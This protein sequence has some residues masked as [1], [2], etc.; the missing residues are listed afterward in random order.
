VSS[1]KELL[2]QQVQISNQIRAVR[3][4]LSE[5][6]NIQDYR[7]LEHE[8]KI[9]GAEKESL[10]AEL[11]LLKTNKREDNRYETVFIMMCKNMLDADTYASIVDATTKRIEGNSK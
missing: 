9:L 4:E 7:R 5:A 11:A 8:L 6:R 1:K 2:K 10:N 3:V